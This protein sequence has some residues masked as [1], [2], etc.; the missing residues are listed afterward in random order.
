MNKT[1]LH[2]MLGAV[3]A[4]FSVSALA[5]DTE[6]V[7]EVL[8]VTSDV[9]LRS[10]NGDKTNATA[11]ALEMYTVRTDGAITKDFVGLMSFSVP[12]KAG[13]S[14]KSATLRLT[15]ERA[16]GTMAIYALGA[17]VSDTDTYNSQKDNIADARANTVLAVVTLKGTTGKS[18]TDAGVSSEIEDWQNYIDLTD[19]VKTLG[20]GNVNLLLTNNAESTTTSIKVYTSDAADVTNTK[21]EP[22]FTFAAADLYPQLTV[23]YQLD[24]DSKS[25]TTTSTA[26]TWIRSGNT[27]KHG[28]ETTMELCVYTNESDASKNKTFLGLMSFQLPTDVT[29]SNYTIKSAQLRLVTERVKGARGIKLY[30]YGTFDENTIYA[31]EESAVTEAINDD[32]LVAS[33]DA[34]GSN[35]AMSYDALP[36]EYQTADAWTNNIDIT[37]YVNSLSDN[38]FS[39]LFVKDNSSESTKF[40][41]RELTEDVVNS[42]DTSIKFAAADL[43]P[44]LTIDYTLANYT[45]NVTD[46]GAATLVLPYEAQIPTGVKAYT[47]TYTSGNKATATEVTDVIP[48]NTPVLVNATAGKYDFKATTKYTTK[49]DSPVSGCLYGAWAETEAPVG[50]YVLQNQSGTVAFY[51]VA[52]AG[53]KISA[54]QAY[55]LAS[56]AQGAGVMNV[57][58]GGITGI[59]DVENADIESA[60]HGAVYTIDG[61]KAD[62]AR[63]SK[64]QVYVTKGKAF[65]VK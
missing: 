53:I 11:N 19:Y 64:G 43:V 1:L 44:Q 33:F 36:T 9:S 26:D 14:V 28:S 62:N 31:N 37:S 58:F 27:T 16:K 55:L 10:D 15:T 52:T 45:L 54:N 56:G 20:N 50:S 63:L 42:Q 23:V 57:E 34:K 49:S 40:Y 5:Q 48:A 13:Y 46:A 51:R 6:D 60:N 18:I 2:C 35:K 59:K 7:T 30:N 29:Y 38:S 25:S 8:S 3:L 65:L 21:V 47:L 32:N 61:K 17:D 41:T 22:K 4:M 24:S 39:L 12:A